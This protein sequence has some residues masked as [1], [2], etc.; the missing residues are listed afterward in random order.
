M[1]IL[2]ARGK[3]RENIPVWK[4]EGGIVDIVNMATSSREACIEDL[5]TK[6][7]T[8]STVCMHFGFMPNKVG[9]PRNPGEAI[10]KLCTQQQ[11]KLRL[12]LCKGSNTLNLF[13]HLKVHHPSTFAELKQAGTVEV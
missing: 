12:V 4:Q 2:Q 6:P 1:N 10:C 9:Q 5:V 3:Q 7:N 11:Q 8:K 13:G